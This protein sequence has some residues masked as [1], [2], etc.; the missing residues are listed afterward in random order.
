M[1]GLAGSSRSATSSS[2]AWPSWRLKGASYTTIPRP[3]TQPEGRTT[4]GSDARGFFESRCLDEPAGRPGRRR[5]CHGLNTCRAVSDFLTLT[6]EDDGKLFRVRV[7]NTGDALLARYHCFTL[8]GQP[9]TFPCFADPDYP[10][11]YRRW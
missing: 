9:F 8:A 7:L 1:A 11:D 3:N 10:E 6:D 5:G 4:D 2:T